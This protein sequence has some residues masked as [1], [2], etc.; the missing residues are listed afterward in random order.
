MQ[1]CNRPINKPERILSINTVSRRLGVSRATI[2]KYIRRQQIVP[3][4]KSDL[5]TYFRPERLSEIRSSEADL[6]AAQKTSPGKAVELEKLLAYRRAV[7]APP[8]QLPPLQVQ[9]VNPQEIPRRDQVIRIQRDSDGL[10]QSATAHQ[11]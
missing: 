1:S 3:D 10:M 5:G 2:E 4:F 7:K 11:V 9:I 8:V 6:L